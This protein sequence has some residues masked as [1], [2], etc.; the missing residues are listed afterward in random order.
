MSALFSPFAL[1]PLKVANR[2]AIAPMCQY[3]AVDGDAGDW[4][5]IHLGHLALSG[6]GV[7]FTEATAV[8]PEGR[9]SAADLGLW[10]DHNAAALA[11]VVAA[12]RR[13]SSMPLVMQLGHAGRKASSAVPWQGGAH[14]ALEQGG[15]TTVAP[16]ALPHAP[17]EPAPKALDAAGLVKVKE[18]FVATA[19]RA[20]ALGFDGV[21]L[22]GPHGYLLHQFLSPVANVRTDDYGG[23]LENR[24]RF[25]LEVFA[26]VRAAVPASMAVGMRISAS[27][28]VEGGWEI[29]QSVVFAQ[30][31]KTAGADFIHVSSGGISPQ[32]KIPLSPGYQIPFA[33]RIRRETGLPTIG[34]GLVTEPAHAEAIVGQGD[35]DMVALARAILYD[36]RWPW[37]AAAQLNAQVAAPPQYWRSQPRELKDL[38]G[39][40]TLGQR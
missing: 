15:W 16:S 6:A 39:S 23:T 5:M 22:H 28:W 32:Q 9:I 2:I 37:H 19:L 13:H 8:L 30:R 27:D 10:S 11:N 36:P 38:F 3:S 40:T 34:V 14:V 4:H 29:E 1:G 7:M 18:A 24:M 31:L 20:H 17:G 26:A 25:P 33:A 21:E 35:A 12:I